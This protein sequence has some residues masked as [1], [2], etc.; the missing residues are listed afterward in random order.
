MAADALDVVGWLTAEVDTSYT[1]VVAEVGVEHGMPVLAFGA[2]VRAL[3]ST[4]VE[5]FPE[6]VKGHF[7][8]PNADEEAYVV[9]AVPLARARDRSTA[10]G[11]RCRLFFVELPFGDLLDCHEF[12]AL[13]LSG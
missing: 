10:V 13:A 5:A 6:S 9:S 11:A 12:D 8:D 4:V 7:E 3:E 1:V 2:L